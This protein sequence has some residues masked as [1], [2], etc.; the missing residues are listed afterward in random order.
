M[1]SPLTTRREATL[2]LSPIS[3]DSLDSRL[4]QVETRRSLNS[5]DRRLALE[6]FRCLAGDGK[7]ITY[8]KDGDNLKIEIDWATNNPQ[9][10]TI[11][12]HVKGSRRNLD[13]HFDYDLS[14]LDFNINTSSSASVHMKAVG[15]NPTF[16]Q[17]KISRDASLKS[18]GNIVSISWT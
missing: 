2:R 6:N 17:Y 1:G 8:L 11:D 15:N 13:L 10:N 4:Q 14:N 7:V 16:G 9:K 18:S 5:M 3:K 12:I